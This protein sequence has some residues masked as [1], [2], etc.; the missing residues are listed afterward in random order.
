MDTTFATYKYLTRNLD[1]TLELKQKEP[2]VSLDTKYY[3]DNIKNVKNLD[4]FMKDTRLYNYAVKAFGLEDMAY[5]KAYMRKVLAEGVTD[6]KAFANRLN[7]D[8]FVAFAEAFDF[9]KNGENTTSLPA[10]GQ[11]LVD[12]YIRQSLERDQG[13]Q[14]EGV[15]LALYFKR[16]APDVSTAYGLLGDQA[17]WKVVKTVYGFPDAMANAAIERQAKV[18]EEK[19]NIEDLKDPAKLERLI[20]RFT[21]MWDATQNVSSSPL[22]QLF[23]GGQRTGLDFSMSL[24]NLKYGG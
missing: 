15:R 8:R 4:D 24:L 3:T 10:A 17:L 16:A 20:Q 9:G 14:N 13:A 12:K 1:R 23:A 21:I 2:T 19:L 7:D 11:Q 18:V 22:L 6:P 5:A